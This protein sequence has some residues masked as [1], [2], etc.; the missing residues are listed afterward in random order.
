MVG[1]ESR[2]VPE[3]WSQSVK[4]PTCAQLSQ[5]GK[6][7]TIQ[8]ISAV[9]REPRFQ[10]HLCREVQHCLAA[11]GL[12]EPGSSYRELVSAFSSGTCMGGC[13]NDGKSGPFADH[14]SQYAF[15]LYQGTLFDKE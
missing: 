9:A 4:Q 6:M 10:G 13:N 3:H 7:Q 12:G 2:G 15:N 5:K 14:H 11:M 8:I 1:S